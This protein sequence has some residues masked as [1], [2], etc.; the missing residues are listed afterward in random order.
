LPLA[1]AG[2]HLL[3]GIA[4]TTGRTFP[5]SA[6]RVRK[7]LR[8]QLEPIFNILNETTLE[9]PGGSVGRTLF[10]LEVR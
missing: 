8:A 4:R 7:F 1:L 9:A 5:I 6:V 2:G 10:L 3:D